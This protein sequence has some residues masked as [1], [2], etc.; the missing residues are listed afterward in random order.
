MEGYRKYF[1][2]NHLETSPR[3]WV[4]P[5]FS[6]SK[7]GLPD[8]AISTQALFA[9]NHFIKQCPIMSFIILPNG[10]RIN[11]AGDEIQWRK[12]RGLNKHKNIFTLS[13]RERQAMPSTRPQTEERLRPRRKWG[14]ERRT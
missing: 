4:P 12:I 5:T 10:R 3:T 13:F 14:C 1:Q 9:T 11:F 7:T 6:A 2:K 8:H